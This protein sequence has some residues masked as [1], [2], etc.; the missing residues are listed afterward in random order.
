M[1]E[2]ASVLD[3]VLILCSVLVLEDTRRLEVDDSF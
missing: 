1:L 2:D 3:D